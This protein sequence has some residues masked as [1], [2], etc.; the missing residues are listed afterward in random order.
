MSQANKHYIKYLLEL[1]AKLEKALQSKDYDNLHGVNEEKIEQFKA[2]LEAL[3]T[4]LEALG[5]TS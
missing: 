5:A 1:E 3:R 2:K 4:N